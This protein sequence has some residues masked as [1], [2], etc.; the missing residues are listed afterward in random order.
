MQQGIIR[1]LIKQVLKGYL[2]ACGDGE[3]RLQDIQFLFGLFFTFM[4]VYIDISSL[5][6]ESSAI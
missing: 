2:P 1:Y 5:K 4:L 6:V 3:F